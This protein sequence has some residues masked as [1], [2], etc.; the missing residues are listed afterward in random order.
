MP[1]ARV[2][3]IVSNQAQ[4]NGCR[5]V[6]VTFQHE[7]GGGPAWVGEVVVP[8]RYGRRRRAILD[9]SLLSGDLISILGLKM[10]RRE[11]TIMSHTAHAIGLFYGKSIKVPPSQEF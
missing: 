9:W 8:R 11:K 2:S 1:T 3:A 5:I 7:L 10:W 6:T 4:S